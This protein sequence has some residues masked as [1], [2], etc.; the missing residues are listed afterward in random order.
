MKK[1]KNLSKSQRLVME[2][3]WKLGEVN[4]PMVLKELSGVR[5][6]SRHTVKTYLNQLVEK[7]FLGEKKLSPRKYYYYPLLTK[8]DFLAD[9]T[10]HYLE[11][12]FKGL[13]YMVAGLVKRERVSSDE[14]ERLE[15]IIQEYK[16][17][18]DE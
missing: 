12:N 10:S 9:E 2:V 13:S 3:I 14:I 4:N 5:D 6:W 8:D 11:R 18:N 1:Q 17:K 16:D 7:G 15:Q